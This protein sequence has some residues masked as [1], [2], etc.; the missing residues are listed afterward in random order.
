MRRV[1]IFLVVLVVGVEMAEG[2][3]AAWW[4]FEEGSGGMVADSSGNGRHGTIVG[5]AVWTEGVIGGALELDGATSVDTADFGLGGK[6]TVCMWVNPAD[7]DD[8]CWIGKHRGSGGNIF[9]IGA[10]D[11]EYQVH[12]GNESISGGSVTTG[13]QHIAVTVEWEHVSIPPGITFETCKIEFYRNGALLWDH[14]FPVTTF[15]S[16]VDFEGKPWTMGQDWD[17]GGRSDFFV[18]AIDD[19]RIYAGEVLS[20]DEIH[21]VFNDDDRDGVLNIDDNC[22]VVPNPD[23]SDSDGDGVGDV[24]EGVLYVGN[25]W[26]ADFARIQDAIDASTPGQTVIVMRGIYREK[27]NMRGKAI[28]LRSTDPTDVAVVVTTVIDG[29]ASGSVITCDSGEGADTVISGFVITNGTGVL[30]LYHPVRKCGGGMYNLSSSPTVSN[31]IFGENRAD[32]GGGM[33]NRGKSSPTVS[34]C[35]FS[36]NTAGYRGGGMYNNESSPT[37]NNCTFSGHTAGYDGGEMNNVYSSPRVSNCTFSDNWARYDGGGMD[38]YDSSPTVINCTFSGNTAN[39]W[40]GGM[41][42]DSDSS[43]RVSD[44]HFCDNE[45]DQVYG[46]YAAGGGRNYLYCPV[47]PV[48][49]GDVDGDGDVDMADL[50]IVAENWLAGVDSITN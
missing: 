27:L 24:C 37:V 32:S 28:T 30:G 50:S 40:G 26:P 38:N 48:Y 1:V 31:C 29:N 2:S 44:S 19:V 25:K 47:G 42:S 17:G 46:V 3:L 22:A 13:W 7:T 14:M 20:E 43:P 33:S 8:Q 10:W 36:G 23:Q 16:V 39:E 9:L 21:D 41:Y 35:T 12:I 15:S 11:G 34:N 6:W 4:E 49:A 45:P 18:G 5:S